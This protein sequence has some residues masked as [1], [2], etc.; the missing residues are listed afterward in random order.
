MSS[1][2]KLLLGAVVGAAAGWVYGVLSAPRPGHET[3]RILEENLREQ[4]D[5]SSTC[6]Q[7]KL[8]CVSHTLDDVAETV[9]HQ[10]VALKAKAVALANELETTGRTTLDHLKN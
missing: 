9:S 5:E 2:G 7:E 1:F 10:A 8:A 4:W 3:R 6:V